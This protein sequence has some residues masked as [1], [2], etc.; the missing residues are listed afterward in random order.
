MTTSWLIAHSWTT[1]AGLV[2]L[3]VLGPP[4]AAWLAGRPRTA[5]R[6]AL[7]AA[8]PVVVLTL[9]PAWPTDGG[10]RCAVATGWPD[11]GAVEPLANVL[12][13]A[14]PVLVATAA[15]RR[16][17]VAAVGASVLS[18]AIE[19]VQAVVPLLGRACDT[20]DWVANS[21]GAVL[22]AVLGWLALTAA[23]R[24]TGRARR[25]SAPAGPRRSAT[26]RSSPPARRG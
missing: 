14:V 8:V 7:L 15:W 2:A 17:V 13:F 24:G 25:A 9:A 18:A 5:R 20:G 19:L 4:L 6:L 26:A 10:V 11:L 21:T 23:G 12:L 3:L 22:G 1:T 16:P